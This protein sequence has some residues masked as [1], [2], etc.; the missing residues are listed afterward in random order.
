MSQYEYSLYPCE[1]AYRANFHV[2]HWL[3][4][5]LNRYNMLKFIIYDIMYIYITTVIIT[6][7]YEFVGFH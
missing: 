2:L 1:N 6:R 4:I 7:V 5:T 3:Y